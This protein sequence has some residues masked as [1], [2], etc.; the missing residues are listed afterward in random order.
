MKYTKIKLERKIKDRVLAL[1]AQGKSSF[2]VTK[3]DFLY[4]SD[5]GG[6]LGDAGNLNLFKASIEQTLK[7]LNIKP[8]VIACDMH[9]EYNSTRLGEEISNA[10][11]I[12]LIKIQHHKAHIASNIIDNNVKGDVIGIAFDGTGY[13]EDGTVWGGEFFIGSLKGLKRAAHLDYIAM[14]G[15]EKAIIEPWRMAFSYLYR[16]NLTWLENDRLEILKQ[17]IDKKINS[18]LTSSMGRLFDAVS[19]LIGVC[20]EAS[21]EGEP[22][23]MLEKKMHEVTSHKS[24]A[25]GKQ[26]KFKIKKEKDIYIIKADD[27]I[28]DIMKDVK[29]KI[30]QGEM[31]LRFHNAVAIMIKDVCKIL[32]KEYKIDKVALSGGVF[33]NKFLTR[34]TPELLEKENF[35]VYLHRNIPT[36]DGGISVGQAVLSSH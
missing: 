11:K 5:A 22:A 34:H 18:P 17:A 4:V 9:P 28:K 10:K 3:G 6:D 20:S 35:K 29:N 8:S 16:A 21:F 13:G 24:Q 31:S 36:H 33:L 27:V 12:P 23:I 1:G 32:R 15:G 30:T 2:S 14:P 7:E 19:S 25:A 26:Y